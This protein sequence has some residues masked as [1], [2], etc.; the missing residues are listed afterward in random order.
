MNAA[1]PNFQILSS[2]KMSG[3]VGEL[4]PSHKPSAPSSPSPPASSTRVAR[5]PSREGVE[6]MQ[7]CQDIVHRMRAEGEKRSRGQQVTW[8][9]CFSEQ[10]VVVN[11][12]FSGGVAS[13]SRRSWWV[14]LALGSSGTSKT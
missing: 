9:G 4:V 13:Y 12:V 1:I 8:T 2:Q 11:C 6:A 5:T 7:K 10:G 14:A 3:K